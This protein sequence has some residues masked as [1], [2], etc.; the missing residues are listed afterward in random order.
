MTSTYK[1]IHPQ[2]KFNGNIYDVRD[3]KEL[4]YSLV[5]EGEEFER[6]IGDFLL[7]WFNGLPILHIGTS[8]STGNPKVI[9]VQKKQMINSAIATGT[10]FNM[11][12][13]T[14]A[15]HCLPA[16]FIAGKMMLVRAM[17]LGW[18][19]HCIQPASSPMIPKGSYYDFCAMVPLQVQNSLPLLNRIGTLIVGGAPLSPEL[20]LK[21]GKLET[22]VYETYGMTETVSHIA[23]KKIADNLTVEPHF[24]A[25]P[26]VV[27]SL[28]E[29]DCLVIEASKILS[30][31]IVTNDVVQLISTSEFLWL[32]R[33]D[34]IINSGGIKLIPEQIERKLSPILSSR[35]FVAGIAD[36][37]LGQK[38]VLL[39]EG[40]V[41][42]GQIDRDIRALSSLSKYE[43]PKAIYS[44][45][46]F[47]ETGTGK[48][49]REATLRA[50]KL[51]C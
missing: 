23:V 41:D 6:A 38:L 40:E 3:L 28:D 46:R 4:A 18:D 5:K 37:V 17:F 45:P 24:I 14:K 35:F 26:D 12:P 25:L 32:G 39:V 48:V 34:H 22:K 10:F 20:R 36:P 19:I 43:V 1:N 44:I 16:D 47:L 30:G 50:I 13:G 42:K 27:L 8:G 11:G 51:E 7:D 2:F 31:T 33:Y 49:K 9:A 21:V 15:L 29:R